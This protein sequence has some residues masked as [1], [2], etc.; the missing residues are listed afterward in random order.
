MYQLDWG[1]FDS[2]TKNNLKREIRI[3][4][5][6]FAFESFILVFKSEKKI[7]I[8]FRESMVQYAIS[9]LEMAR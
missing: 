2:I 6:I 8:L 3:Y 5:I 7:L 4:T 1:V 9:W